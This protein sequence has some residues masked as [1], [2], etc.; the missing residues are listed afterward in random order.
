MLKL[1]DY[2]S[3]D[4]LKA[5]CQTSDLVGWYRVFINYAL[6]SIAIIVLLSFPY[7]YTFICCSWIIG[8]RILGIA[9][10]NHDA[11]HNTLFRTPSLNHYVGR[12]LLGGLVLVDYQAFKNGHAQH[13]RYAGT[14]KDP[15]K[16]FVANY[17]ATPASMA[18][19]LLRDFSG[20]N[21]FKEI[22]YQ[23][24]VSTWQKRLPNIV[25]HG[26]FIASLIF[27][28]VLWTYAAFW[29]GYLFIYPAL[30]R[31]RIIGEHGAVTD[32]D[33]LD[34]RLNTRTTLANPIVALL[35]CPNDVNYHLEHHIHQKIPAQNLKK[36]HQLFK[37][38]GMYDGFDCVANNY[39]Q[40]MKKCI[41]KRHG[42][43]KNIH[44]APSSVSNM[45]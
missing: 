38:K 40:V 37:Q 16:I 32:I 26:I 45:S 35:I 24:K 4:E 6:I 34:P 43:S 13:H 33:A 2:I 42:K 30:S 29:V 39:W 44:H 7:W 11:G 18:R 12:W 17:P 20:V 8:G 3:S 9:I 10:L 27:F 22:I 15:D 21:G 1:S 25:V 23:I 41:S 14:G 28:D 36:A 5:L 19:K 31:I